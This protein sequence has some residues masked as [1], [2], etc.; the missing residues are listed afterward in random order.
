MAQKKE[1]QT[2]EGCVK[3][4]I[5]AGDT[6]LFPNIGKISRITKEPARRENL[7]LK[8]ICESTTR[9]TQNNMKSKEQGCASTQGRFW[10]KKEKEE[11]QSNIRK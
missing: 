10:K 2:P 11:K 6:I 8:N 1:N 9:K 7:M 3:L 5:R 4:V